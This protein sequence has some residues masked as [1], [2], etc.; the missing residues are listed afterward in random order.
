MFNKLMPVAALLVVLVTSCKKDVGEMLVGTWQGKEY[1][2]DLATSSM[3]ADELSKA[4]G[5]ITKSTF[6]TFKPDGTFIES[7]FK[8]ES[9]GK[10]T[11]NDSS[12]IL[13]LSYS[14]IQG[15]QDRLNPQYE[16]VSVTSEELK[17][18]NQL[19]EKVYE[20]LTFV[21]K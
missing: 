4:G 18:K 3:T 16:V 12:K 14:D 7:V 15:P 9:T 5:D 13:K 19:G 17:V 2:T 8:I 11:Y 21:K 1:K 10:W 6:Y 20:Y